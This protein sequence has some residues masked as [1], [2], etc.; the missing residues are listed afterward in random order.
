MGIALAYFALIVTG[1][2]AFLAIPVALIAGSDF[3]M[4]QT[5]WRRAGILTFG[6][7]F[8]VPSVIFLVIA[9]LVWDDLTGEPIAGNGILWFALVMEAISAS[10][11]VP[12][13]AVAFGVGWLFGTRKFKRLTQQ[14]RACDGGES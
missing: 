12:V 13:T 8:A 1:V 2:V 11:L 3:G 6:T 7:S 5:T 10:I 9:M 4:R 14:T